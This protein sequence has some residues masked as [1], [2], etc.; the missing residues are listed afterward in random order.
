MFSAVLALLLLTQQLPALAADPCEGLLIVAKDVDE[1]IP[2]DPE[3]RAAY[4]SYLQSRY[5]VEPGTVAWAPEFPIVIRGGGE[6]TY[7]PKADVE[8]AVADN[9]K[10]DAIIIGSGP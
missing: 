1:K 9:G 10:Y 2:D 8:H 4:V 5:S 3:K 7:F 6:Q